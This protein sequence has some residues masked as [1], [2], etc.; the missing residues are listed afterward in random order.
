M[1]KKLEKYNFRG[2]FLKLMKSFLENRHQYVEY[3]NSVSQK[4]KLNYG[5]PQGSVLGPLF[6]LLYFNDLPGVCNSNKITLFA[7]DTTNY[8][9]A[10]QNTSFFYNEVKEPKRWFEEHKLTTNDKKCRQF[11]NFGKRENL[12]KDFLVRNVQNVNKITYL[13]IIIDQKLNYKSHV[14][15][16]AKQMS[17]FCGV[18]YE[19][20]YY[21]T[22]NQLLLFYESYAK[23]L[24]TYGLI[25]Y[26]CT[27]NR[28]LNDIFNSQKRIF[29]A[30]FFKRKFDS[31]QSIMSKFKLFNIFELYISEIFREV[32]LQLADK[33][34]HKFLNK[35]ELLD[36]RVTRNTT[37][38]ILPSKH[39]K[40]TEKKSLQR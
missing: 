22:K 32:F 28:N 36:R 35:K 26:G 25:V 14:E 34:V 3:N 7:D 19:A 11:M 8:S 29:R 10:K 33:S 21:L 6:F 12:N 39:H 30:I 23:S 2:N 9:A 40:E 18:L 5:V 24:I 4:L 38:G 17:K 20:R 1:I 37:K 31:V 15:K 13:G 27:T 16:I